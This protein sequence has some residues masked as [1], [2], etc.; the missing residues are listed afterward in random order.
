MRKTDLPQNESLVCIQGVTKIACLLFLWSVIFVP[1]IGLISG[2]GSTGHEQN[3]TW[4]TAM[5]CCPL[6]ARE[7]R[8]ISSPLSM[9]TRSQSH[10]KLYTVIFTHSNIV[11]VAFSVEQSYVSSW[12]S[13]WCIDFAQYWKRQYPCW[14]L[15]LSSCEARG[16]AKGFGEVYA[17]V[18]VLST[19]KCWI[20]NSSF[21]LDYT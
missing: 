15:A 4:N 12:E 9:H 18:G 20:F 6:L 16:L 3:N 14:C 2:V 1:L 8:N 5:G 19:L 7:Q 17:K 10:L 13:K 11:R 21:P